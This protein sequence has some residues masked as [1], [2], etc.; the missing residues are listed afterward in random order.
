[1]RLKTY[2]RG[3]G[4]GIIVTA[5]VMGITGG[6]EE[7][8]TEEEIVARAKELGMVETEIITMSETSPESEADNESEEQEDAQEESTVE[9]AAVEETSSEESQESSAEETEGNS[10]SATETDNSEDESVEGEQTEVVTD[11]SSQSQENNGIV[12]G[13]KVSITV[14][15]GDDSAAVSRKLES[16][17]LVLSATDYDKFLCDNGY[18]RKLSPGNYEVAIG[19]SDETIA[20][21]I[22][23][24]N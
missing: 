5:L 6:K 1:M 9:A 7:S 18:A 17:G 19:S 4:I 11:E 12:A 21:I 20:K 13:Q 2:L 23:K 8:L 3:L 10:I 22:T 24:S 14:V 15:S 16:A